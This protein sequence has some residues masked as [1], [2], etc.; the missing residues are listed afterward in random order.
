MSF[1]HPKHI[2]QT[3][4]VV[5]NFLKSW[6]IVGKSK[7]YRRNKGWSTSDPRKFL[8]AARN[9]FL[10]KSNCS[11]S[12][13]P[14]CFSLICLSCHVTNIAAG[15]FPCKSSK[16]LLHHMFASNYKQEQDSISY[17]FLFVLWARLTD[18]RAWEGWEG[19]RGEDKL[20]QQLWSLEKRTRNS[21]WYIF[22]GFNNFK[23][24]TFIQYY[25]CI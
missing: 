21:F 12:Q 5:N 24:T 1:Y 23:T 11:V 15:P 7:P 20:L 17:Q 3:W 19:D 16:R 9:K 13:S 25:L 8:L 10:N 2:C 18:L 6:Q 14:I 4:S 22:E